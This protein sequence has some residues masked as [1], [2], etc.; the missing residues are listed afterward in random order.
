MGRVAA[1]SLLPTLFLVFATNR[2]GSVPTTG[3]DCQGRG[4]V[5]YVHLNCVDRSCVP[6]RKELCSIAERVEV[7]VE[8]GEGQT[9]KL[10]Q[11]SHK[12]S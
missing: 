2:K 10:N 12:E 8:V 3:K 7:F 11:I 6:S 9:E 4:K 5:V 1:F